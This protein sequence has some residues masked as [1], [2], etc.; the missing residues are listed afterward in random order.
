MR[1]QRPENRGAAV[2]VDC[3][4]N[5]ENGGLVANRERATDARQEMVRYSVDA[6]TGHECV[7]GVWA[8]TGERTEPLAAERTRRAA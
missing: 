4:S 7:L 3:E 5:K 2:C 1:E 8:S 6:D